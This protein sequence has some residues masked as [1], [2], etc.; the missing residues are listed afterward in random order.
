VTIA[1]VEGY[2]IGI[3]WSLALACDFVVASDSAYFIAPFLQHGVIPD[4]GIARQLIST[5]GLHRALELLLLGRKVPAQEA[6]ELGLVN[7][8]APAG[9]ALDEALT[10]ANELTSL[11]PSSVALTKQLVRKAHDLPLSEHFDHE[12]LVSALN[13]YL[14]SSY[15]PP[16]SEEVEDSS[17]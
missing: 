12:A 5:V 13:T 4:G 7:R 11:Q 8:L 10:I 15:A 17:T 9:Q 14:Q 3:G 1:A 2:A 6:M 16:V